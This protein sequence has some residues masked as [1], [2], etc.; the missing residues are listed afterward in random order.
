MFG[1]L[2]VSCD[3]AVLGAPSA[4]LSNIISIHETDEMSSLNDTDD[5]D[6][7]S[8]DG[9][10]IRPDSSISIHHM[11]QNQENPR[12]AAVP[13]TPLPISQSP[14][15]PVPSRDDPESMTKL[16]NVI[17]RIH[18]HHGLAPLD[19]QD[20]PPLHIQEVD[21]SVT[22]NTK[23][24]KADSLAT[25]PDATTTIAADG[26]ATTA[27]SQAHPESGYHSGVSSEV[28]ERLKTLHM[29][30]LPSQNVQMVVLFKKLTPSS[31]TIGPVVDSASTSSSN[32]SVQPSPELFRTGDTFG[33]EI[34]L[35]TTS[36]KLSSLSEEHI[37]LPREYF[38]VRFP[39]EMVR[40]KGGRQ[41]S[42]LTQMTYIL[43]LSIELG[44]QGSKKSSSS[45]RSNVGVSAKSIPE[46]YEEDEEGHKTSFGDG[47]PLYSACKSCAKFLHEHKKL[48]PSR[49]SSSDP[50]QYPIVQ[51]SIPGGTST[52]VTTNAGAVNTNNSGVVELRD[53]ACDVNAKVNCSSFH[54]LLQRERTK[55]STAI[56]AQQK[57]L[58]QGQEQAQETASASASASASLSKEEAT[59]TA[60]EAK[61]G[62]AAA[63]EKMAKAL[64]E[65]EDP[66]YVFKFELVHPELKT[67]VAQ[68]ETRPILFQSFARGR[69]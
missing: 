42:I 9:D 7:M 15:A 32:L 53:G 35:F 69:N 3:R 21:G 57:K 39:H 41:A 56:K 14:P 45:D 49:R 19:Q 30:T 6:E 48:S 43:N 46:H 62:L 51:F 8:M 66:G 18:V 68:F 1:Y 58:E 59:S 55:L 38:G 29:A 20:L 4:H 28:Q 64:A 5:E 27:S 22:I 31:P 26:G 11:S 54:H 24:M 13:T 52:V 65:L 34:R 47:I 33:I 40:R 23:V 44:K 37:S 36:T 16:A 10:I 60:A 63:K 50:T 2:S 12:V 67:V 17:H 61:Q 25:T